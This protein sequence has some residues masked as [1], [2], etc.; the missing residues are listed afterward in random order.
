[1]AKLLTKRDEIPEIITAQ[2][3]P[4]TNGLCAIV[5]ITDFYTIGQWKWKA[6]KSA[7]IFYAVR[8][9]YRDG[10]YHQ[11]KM[12]RFIMQ[13]PDKFEVH[14]MNGNSLDNRRSNLQVVDP[15][16]HRLFHNKKI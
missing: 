11:I 16:I 1:M 12:H 15:K 4:L 8:E 10:Q 7:H 5:D 2:L 6:K 3:I 9:E 13:C 14:H